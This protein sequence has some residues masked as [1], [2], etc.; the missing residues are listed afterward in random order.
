MNAK[1]VYIL[2]LLIAAIGLVVLTNRSAIMAR[3]PVVKAY[4]ARHRTALSW[5]FIGLTFST[6]AVV[7]F[8][9]FFGGTPIGA[10]REVRILASE[11]VMELRLPQSTLTRSFNSKARLGQ[12]AAGPLPTHLY[13][14]FTLGADPF[15]GFH[16]YMDLAV[17]DGWKPRIRQFETQ[18]RNRCRPTDTPTP[19]VNYTAVYLKDYFGFTAILSLHLRVPVK[20][21]ETRELTDER[22]NLGINASVLTRA[23][24]RGSGVE[25]DF[26][27]PVPTSTKAFLADPLCPDLDRALKQR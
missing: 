16:R 13:R 4:S 6:L 26:K 11:R 21:L 22:P 2:L 20:D 25:K 15:V 8:R 27:L 5:I 24:A 23:S 18:V 9:A 3:W 7:M 14:S 12:I 19:E 1:T 10:S 17:R